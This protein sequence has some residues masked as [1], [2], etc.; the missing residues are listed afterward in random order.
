MGIL[1]PKVVARYD[2]ILGVLPYIAMAAV[3]NY[4]KL[5]GLNSKLFTIL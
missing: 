1:F 5:G 4:C 2:I 3:T